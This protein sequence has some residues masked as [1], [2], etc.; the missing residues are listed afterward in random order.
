MLNER[1]ITVTRPKLVPYQLA[2][3]NSEAR[4]TVT[5][6]ATKIGKTYSHS[7]WLFQ[8]A[9][10]PPKPGANY[11][12]VA[13]VYSQAEIAFNRVR[14]FLGQSSDFKIN[15]S[16]ML[17]ET[18]VESFL[19]YKSA[20]DP[21]S[22]YGEDVFAAVFDEFTRAKEEAWFAL[23][24]TLTHTKGPCKFIGNSK[25]KKNW[26]H[27]LW[28][29][30]SN[31][32]PGYAAFKVTAYDAVKAGIL[33]AE[34][35]EQAKRDLPDAAFRELYLAEDLEDQA[36]PFGIGAIKNC[37]SYLSGEE[38][39]CFGVDLAKSVDW[40]VITGLDVNGQVC[41]FDRF[42]KDWGQTT[43]AV[44]RAIGSTKANIDS[45]GVGD[46]I[47]EAIKKKCPNAISFKFTQHSKQQIMERL[48]VS[49]Q[50]N[51]ISILEGPMQDELEN[52]EFQYSRTGV[53]YSAP[54]GLHDD[55]VCSLALANEL[56]TKPKGGFMGV[57]KHKS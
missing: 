53:K 41:Y 23:R 43:E 33:D 56:H 3:L 31:G 37:V 22:L 24:S 8:E 5:T 27:R 50:N 11:W 38:A 35:V 29:K 25:G 55:C 51:D 40:T 19:H 9:G 48:A 4:F 7:W 26:G 30:A 42:Q 15:L 20:Q 44:I 34:E 32:E 57:T 18:P 17:I 54:D 36:N 6:A 14:R 21:D 46:A 2:I 12:W 45:T 10:T 13:P 16:K 39:V 28:V 52:F 47:Y 1:V 49:I